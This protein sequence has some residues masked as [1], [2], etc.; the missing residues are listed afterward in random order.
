MLLIS[1]RKEIPFKATSFQTTPSKIPSQ[2][3]M[4]KIQGKYSFLMMESRVF[5]KYK[6][7]LHLLNKVEL[8][9]IQVIL[10]KIQVF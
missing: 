1:K 5:P 8:E 2:I 4:V 10:Q 3:L 7:L 9:R 6:L